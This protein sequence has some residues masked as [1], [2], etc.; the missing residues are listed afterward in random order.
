M[1]YC[2]K[3]LWV[4]LGDNYDHQM[5]NLQPEKFIQV[6][7]SIKTQLHLISKLV[8]RHWTQ[9]EYKS[10]KKNLYLSLK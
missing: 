10:H 5:G 9:W 3:T 2:R 7:C 4:G 6:E 8:A 1:H